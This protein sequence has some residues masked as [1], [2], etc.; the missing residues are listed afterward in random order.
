MIG[1]PSRLMCIA[2]DPVVSGNPSPPPM[3]RD[4]FELMPRP[5]HGRCT[6]RPGGSNGFE[7]GAASGSGKRLGSRG[8][9]ARVGYGAM[10]GLRDGGGVSHLGVETAVAHRTDDGAWG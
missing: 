5:G 6:L 10:A 9:E 3:H 7:P 1:L 4:W 8:R 2:A